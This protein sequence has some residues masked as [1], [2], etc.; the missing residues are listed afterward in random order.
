MSNL[1]EHRATVG[2][3]R[4]FRRLDGLGAHEAFDGGDR[5]GVGAEIAA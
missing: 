4:G 3:T 5:V 2:S 1:H